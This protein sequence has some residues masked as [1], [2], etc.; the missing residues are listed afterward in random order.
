MTEPECWHGKPHFTKKPSLVS[1]FGTIM[2]TAIACGLPTICLVPQ[3]EQLLMCDNIPVAIRRYNS[4]VGQM[5][6][7]FENIVV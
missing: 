7:L 3:T 4:D 1:H 5:L 2:L 6:L